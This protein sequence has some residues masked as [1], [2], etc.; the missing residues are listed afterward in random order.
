M[1][2]I[3]NSNQWLS[4]PVA[5]WTINYEA[6]RSGTD[7]LIR[8]YWK[9]WLGSSTAYYY[10]GFQLQLFL[11]GSQKNITV[12][13]QNSSE[14]GW[15]YEG[16]TGWYTVPNKTSGT[17]SFYAKL[18]DTNSKTTEVTSSTYNLSVAPNITQKVVS[19]TET[20][21]TMQWQSDSAIDYLW[22]SINGGT[23][24]K[25]V[26]SVANVKSGTYTISGLTANKQHTIVTMARR[27]EGQLTG[28]S[29]HDFVDTYDYPHCTS[30]P[31]FKIGDAVT[32]K[33][34]NPLHQRLRRSAS[35]QT[36]GARGPRRPD[37]CRS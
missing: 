32:L 22:Y 8:F 10:Y 25:A 28:E 12:K 3:F 19:K 33:F 5:Y 14:Y 23:D 11:N 36:C 6:K 20:S 7:T 21:I 27:K 31:D 4:S 30:T 1:V 35:W 15:S 26:G 13:S 18:Y 24:W 34:Y 9:V 29:G 2:T 17:V 16:T 37:S